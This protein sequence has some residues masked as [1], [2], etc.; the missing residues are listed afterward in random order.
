MRLLQVNYTD[1]P[2]NFNGYALNRELRKEGVWAKQIVLNKSGKEDDYR[3][4][5]LN[6]DI[7]LHQIL[8][9]AEDKYSVSNLLYPYAR[10]FINSQE[11][12]QADVVHY[13]ILHRFMF[14]L[15]DYPTL[16]NEKKTVWTIHDP[17]LITGNCVHPLSCEKWK[18]G[19]G[20]CDRLQECGFEM[21]EDRTALMWEI[22]RRVL[23]QVNPYIVVASE[24]MEDYLHNSPITNHFDK[25]YKIPFGVRLELYDLHRKEE[26]R[27]QRGVSEN[28]I[29]VGFRADDNLIKGCEYIYEALQGLEERGN[30]VLAVVGNGTVR[31]DIRRS[32]SILELGWLDT[33]NQVADFMLMCDI[34]L[35]PSLAESFGYMAIEAMAAETPVISFAGTVVEEITDAP[36]C[37]I[38]VTYRSAQDLKDAITFLVSNEKTRKT[39]GGEGRKRV[40]K[41][42]LFEDYVRRHRELYEEILEE[43]NTNGR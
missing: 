34:F 5:A 39:M 18:T 31:E 13:H 17:W 6:K 4:S 32:Y 19:C 20:A 36:K 37:G 29:V 3:V 33:E 30:I 14:S 41:E 1:L 26:I 22:K 27:R 10:S 35:M 28:K 16:M 24:F 11:F 21:R 8:R 43:D 23:K 42:Y 9:W 25:I 7:V 2:G 15:F 40:K 38:S 12:M